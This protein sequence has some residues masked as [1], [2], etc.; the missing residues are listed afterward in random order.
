[1]AR[2]NLWRWGVLGLAG[3]Y[4]LV[5]LAASVVFTVDVP[6]Q[7]VTFDAYTRIFSTPASGRACCSRWSWPPPPSSS[8]CC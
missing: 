1:M 5:P 4:F 7:G 2:L 6:G 8:S 3:L